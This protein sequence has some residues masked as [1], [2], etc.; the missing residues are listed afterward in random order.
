M[1]QNLDGQVCQVGDVRSEDEIPLASQSMVSTLCK[2]S[3][4]GAKCHTTCLELRRH[5]GLFRHDEPHEQLRKASAASTL[6][7]RRGVRSSR[8]S[9]FL[10]A[11]KFARAC[12][13]AQNEDKNWRI[14]PER[15]QELYPSSRAK[16]CH[17]WVSSMRPL[18]QPRP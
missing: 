18:S 5:H 15:I 17:A 11:S 12:T 10:G 9:H 1:A 6:D 8:S 3:H 4:I 7:V 14:C 13:Q 2:S 16:H